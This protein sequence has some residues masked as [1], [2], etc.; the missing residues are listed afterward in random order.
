M[1]AFLW[2]E[3]QIFEINR[4][5]EID[6]NTYL[7]SDY[8]EDMIE[9]TLEGGGHLWL[10]GNEVKWSGP[11]LGTEYDWDDVNNTWII[12]SQR[13][14]EKLKV[15]QA[16]MW[17]KIKDNRAHELKA[18]IYIKSVDK[19][20][21]ND[22]NS[23]ALY[24]QYATMINLGIFSPV[25]WKTDDNTFI[26]LTEDILKDILL[27]RAIHTQQVFQKAEQQKIEMESLENPLEFIIQ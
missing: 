20:F 27:H 8:E 13:A 10:A 7:I 11:S 22:E 24:N 15:E 3:K 19:Y 18:D 21:S 2:R 12:N 6:K 9:E 26:E 14:A 25:Q 16:I 4:K 23:V 17:S 5:E 1:K